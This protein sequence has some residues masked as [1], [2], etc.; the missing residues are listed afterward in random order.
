MSL[1]RETRPS[2]SCTTS[3]ATSVAVARDS[4]DMESV[5][6]HDCSARVNVDPSAFDSGPEDARCPSCAGVFLE[7]AGA[8]STGNRGGNAVLSVVFTTG[9]GAPTVSPFGDIDFTQFD[10]RNFDAPAA[11]AVVEALET[12]EVD[13][14]TSEAT[15]SVC[16]CDFETGTSVKR[17]PECKHVFHENCLGD[18]LKL[19]RRDV[20]IGQNVPR[21]TR[22]I[23]GLG[24]ERYVSS[25]SRQARASQGVLKTSR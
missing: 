7:R 1:R 22:V 8:D 19:V 21:L 10:T 18:W 3:C 23:F 6:C 25:L 20:A 2:S 13:E 16:L 15:C 12:V 17:I 24:A 4:A 9:F 14:T 11:P 5:W